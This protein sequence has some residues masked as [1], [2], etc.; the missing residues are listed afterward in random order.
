MKKIR[1]GVI[2]AGSIAAKHI[3]GIIAS[4]DA[5]LAAICDVDSAALNA[6]ADQYGVDTSHRFTDYR[7]LIDCPAVDAVSVCTSNH[8]HYEIAK[9]AIHKGLPLLLEKPVAMDYTQAEELSMLAKEHNVPNMIAFSYR[10][11]PAVRF[12]RR[13]VREGHLGKILH[14]YGQYFQSW[15]ISEELELVWRFQKELSGSGT[16]GDLGSHLIDLAR[17]V[18]GEYGRVCAQAGTFVTKRK[19]IGSDAYGDV[20][21][22]DYCHFLASM[23]DGAGAVFAV[24]RDA[25]GRGN[26]QR[27]E[28]YGTKGALVYKMDE[29][30]D[31]DATIEACIGNVYAEDRQFKT[32]HIPERFYSDQMQ[33]FFDIIRHKGDGLAADI[34]DGR[35]NQ[36]I[37]DSIIQSSEDGKWIDIKG[38]AQYV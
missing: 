23:E 3:R 35:I 30:G 37:L 13:L 27:L 7:A 34:E 1:M 14:I 6:R 12:A 32:L 10:F 22:D 11:I 15:A 25:Y 9:A 2:G 19:I 20:D 17:F 29:K 5:E 38:G 26:Y 31:H 24:T 36:L 4:P 8:T 28:I 33:S 21:V 16:L 18:V